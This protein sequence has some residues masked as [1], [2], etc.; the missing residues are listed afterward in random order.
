M[1]GSFIP[2]IVE[3]FLGTHVIN[4]KTPGFDAFDDPELLSAVKKKGKSN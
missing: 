1:N 4:R 2:E 3:M